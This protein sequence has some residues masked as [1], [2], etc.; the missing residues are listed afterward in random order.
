MINSLPRGPV[1]RRYPRYDDGPGSQSY[2]GRA[3][4]SF[5]NE[6][7]ASTPQAMN[8]TGRILHTAPH[9]AAEATT[10]LRTQSDR[11]LR[12]FVQCQADAALCR[13]ARFLRPS[14][15]RRS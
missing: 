8:A 2:R 5:H 13:A 6:R 3:A 1:S 7:S 12:V 14:A 4:R 9:D 11:L 15:M 10:V